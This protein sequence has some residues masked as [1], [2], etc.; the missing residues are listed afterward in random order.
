RGGGA[1]YHSSGGTL[2]VGNSTFDRNS[3]PRF[4]GAIDI[5]SPSNVTVSDS[6]FTRNTSATGAIANLISGSTLTVNHS[7]FSCNQAIGDCGCA[8]GGAIFNSGVLTVIDS[9]STEN[10][11][12]VHGGAID[13]GPPTE[14]PPV[15]SLTVIK[16]IFSDNSAGSGG[17]IESNSI[18]VTVTNSTFSRNSAVLAGAILNDYG[19]LTVANSTFSGNRGQLGAGIVQYSMGAAHLGVTNSTFTENTATCTIDLCG[20]PTGG[21]I[22]NEGGAGEVTNSTFTGNTSQSG[23]GAIATL[24]TLTLTVTNSILAN[25]PSEANCSSFG[26]AITDGGHNIDTGTT[27]GFVGT[28]CAYCVG[29]DVPGKGCV[30]DSDCSGTPRTP[31][32]TCAATTGTSFCKTDPKLAP[33]HCVGGDLPGGACST[34]LDC[35]GTPPTPNGTCTALA[36]NGGPT[37]TIALES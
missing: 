13:N 34:D 8:S 1:I 31:N 32:G 2:T 10:T 4:G 30:A 24:S 12:D 37:Q 17:A 33:A 21:A 23:G 9:P 26:A 6:T 35:T 11:A 18:T 3:A 25:S 22:H 20:R 15:S 14:A 5:P 29:G 19:T 36:D 7:T 16:S 27:C 28:N